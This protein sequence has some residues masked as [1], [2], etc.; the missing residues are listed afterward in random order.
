M[1]AR[2]NGIFNDFVDLRA[3]VPDGGDFSIDVRVNVGMVDVSGGDDFDLNICTAGWLSR[4]S[5]SA[6]WGRGILVVREFE[7][8]EIESVISSYVDS[9]EAENWAG[10]VAK[11]SRVMRWEF[12]DY[13]SP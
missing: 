12:D 7:F 13:Q 8:S 1:R 4:N 3:W 5:P 2:L 9:C 11:L 6:L 10:I